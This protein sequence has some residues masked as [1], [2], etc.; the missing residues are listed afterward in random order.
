MKRKINVY[1]YFIL[2]V[3][4]SLKGILYD[5][6][7]AFST[8]CGYTLLL[9]GI[10]Y[11]IKVINSEDAK[12]ILPVIILFI[13]LLIY[14]VLFMISGKSYYHYMSDEYLS[15][16]FYLL[17]ILYSFLPIFSVFY[18]YC[19]ELIDINDIKFLSIIL[20]VCSIFEYY[21]IVQSNMIMMKGLDGV[22]TVNAG[23]SFVRLLPMIFVWN[24]NRLF[25]ILY[26]VIIF[27]F[28]LISVKRGAI[29]TLAC[30]IVYFLIYLRINNKIN[31]RTVF[32]LSIGVGAAFL[33]IN[34]LMKNMAYFTYRLDLTLHGS[35]SQRD[36]I[37]DYFIHHL[38]NEDDVFKIFLGNGA[39]STVGFYGQYAHNDW[40]EI[41]MNQGLLGIVAFTS[42]F[43]FFFKTL[44]KR[45]IKQNNPS[46]F[47]GMAVVVL[48]IPS[49]FSMSYSEIGLSL[50]IPLMYGVLGKNFINYV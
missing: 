8:I 27:V 18:F 37:Y 20:L 47:Y 38:L 44:Y 43:M 36:E 1:L 15:S 35:S 28:I 34:Y 49:F 16:N 14:G 26:A 3:L 32:I 33:Y 13:I 39:F 10:I 22:G 29:L 9:L 25:Q 7:G 11:F 50:G 45:N 19:K 5:S 17:Q 46:L 30:G 42:F 4:S 41:A 23:Y 2:S 48:F 24:K 21:H 6:G 31:L 12:K 40:L